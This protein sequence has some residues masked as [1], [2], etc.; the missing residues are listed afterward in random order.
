MSAYLRF[1]DLGLN[2]LESGYVKKDTQGKSSIVDKLQE[3]KTIR[4]LGS[5]L[6]QSSPP[7]EQMVSPNEAEAAQQPEKKHE[8]GLY[9][10]GKWYKL[11]VKESVLTGDPV[12]DLDV[13]ILQ[14]ELLSPILNIEDPRTDKRIAF[15]GGILGME[16][17]QRKVKRWQKRLNKRRKRCT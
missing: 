9:I 2:A 16:P 10:S 3:S 14:N 5:K 13:S 12:N 17:W 15:V 8:M 7:S 4:W 6:E 1:M 11:S